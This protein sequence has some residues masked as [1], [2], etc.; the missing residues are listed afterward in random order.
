MSSGQVSSASWEFEISIAANCARVWEALACESERWWPRDF[1]TSE[2]TRRFVIEAKVGGRV[3][4]DFGNDEGLLWYS[5]LGVDG[6][7][8][9][10]LAGHLLPPFGG[11]AVTALRITLAPTESGTLLKIRDD[12]FG[13]LGGDSPIEGWR[14]VF[15][16]GLRRYV[17]SGNKPI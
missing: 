16:G 5:V 9:L 2:R 12:R 3:F 13:V 11:P 10:L 4:E 6:G 17:E 15:D 8:E 1:V 14:Q 7:K